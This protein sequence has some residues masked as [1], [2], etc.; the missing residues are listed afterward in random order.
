M[1]TSDKRNANTSANPYICI[2][3]EDKQTAQVELCKNKAERKDKFARAAID[4][5][6]LELEDVGKKIK[7]IRL[8]HDNK[9][10]GP[11]K[12]FSYLF[13]SIR[14]LNRFASI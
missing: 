4:R 7:K 1:Y 2:Y 10:L 3:G 13:R 11:G 9:G 12:L 5:F 6:V 14:H 8:G